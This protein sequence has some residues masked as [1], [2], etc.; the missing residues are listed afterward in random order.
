MYR[1]WTDTKESILVAK[2]SLS[3]QDLN[4]VVAVVYTSFSRII[5]LNSHRRAVSSAVLSAVSLLIMP[6]LN[7]ISI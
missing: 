1:F 7:R 2:R 5:C 6:I 4:F 3:I